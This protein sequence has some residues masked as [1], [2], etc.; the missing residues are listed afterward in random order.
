MKSVPTVFIALF[1][2]AASRGLRAEEREPQSNAEI[3]VRLCGE[4][5]EN[6]LAEVN[7]ADTSAVELSTEGGE[8]SRFFGPVLVQTFRQHFRS[9]YSRPGISTVQINASVGN[10]GVKYSE[11]FSDGIFS[12]GKSERTIALSLQLALTRVEDGKVIW[13]GAKS[14]AHKDTVIV[15]DIRDLEKSSEMIARGVQ[16]E[17]SV[18][19]RFFEPI[20]IA[21]AAGVAVYLFFTIRS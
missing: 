10:I 1:I 4:A 17:R 7:I 13:A 6:F 12:A 20:I 19:E 5:A 21:G 9:L 14:V 15:S 18:L 2:L 16:P 3:M 8:A 11:V